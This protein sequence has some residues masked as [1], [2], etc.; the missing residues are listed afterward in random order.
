[1]KGTSGTGLL[2]GQR[3]AYNGQLTTSSPASNSVTRRMYPNCTQ[4]PS[5]GDAATLAKEYMLKTRPTCIPDGHACQQP[6][7]HM[8]C[9]R[10]LIQIIAEP[11]L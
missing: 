9:G 6:S 5:S 2:A 3:V 7:L 8:G 10:Y 11:F 4:R 1:M